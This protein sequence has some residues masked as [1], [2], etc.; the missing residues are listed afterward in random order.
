MHRYIIV[1]C[2]VKMVLIGWLHGLALFSIF[3]GHWPRETG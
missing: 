1:L 3:L 2:M